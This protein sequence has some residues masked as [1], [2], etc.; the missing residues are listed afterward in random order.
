MAASAG[1]GLGLGTLAAGVAV[2]AVVGVVGYQVIFAPGPDPVAEG[3]P[4]GIAGDPV[5]VPDPDVSDPDVEVAVETPTAATPA[6]PDILPDLIAPRFD[7]V[8][9]D[10][11]GGALIAGQAES[12]AE[13]RLLLDGQEIHLASSDAGGDFVAMFDIPPSELPRI[14]SLEMLMEDGSVLVSEQSVII[15]P[16]LRPVGAAT[17]VE[18]AEADA[19][20]PDVPDDSGMTELSMASEPDTPPASGTTP[21]A[22]ATP[23]LPEQT[24]VAAGGEVGTAPVRENGTEV[25]VSV[26]DE[27]P[28]G[29]SQEPAALAEDTG[30]AGEPDLEIASLEIAESSG[31]GLSRGLQP[32]NAATDTENAGDADAQSSE[33]GADEPTQAAAGDAP[34]VILDTANV[35]QPDT[36]DGVGPV[37]VATEAPAADRDSPE[38]AGASGAD[39]PAALADGTGAPVA[40]DSS[41][42]VATASL[43]ENP[44]PVPE[45]SGPSAS[46]EGTTG[47]AT[48]EGVSVAVSDTVEDDTDLATTQGT[49]G[50]SADVD[51]AASGDASGTAEENTAQAAA[52]ESGDSPVMDMDVADSSADSPGVTDGNTELA[53]AQESGDSPVMDMDVADSSAD[54]QGATDGNTELA[55]AQDAADAPAAQNGAAVS[56][57]EAETQPASQPDVGVTEDGSGDS[58]SD[59]TQVAAAD[60]SSEAPQGRPVMEPQTPTVLLA[61][62]QGIRVIQSGDEAPQ[63]QSQVTLDTIAYDTVGDVVLAGRGPAESDVR[64]YLNNQPIHL[65]QINLQGGWR[66]ALP[67]VDPGTY[68]LRLDEVSADGAVQSRIETPFLRE[69]PEAVAAITSASGENV[70]TVQWGHTLWGIAQQH[71][72]EGVAYVQIYEANR[73]QIRNPDLIYPG[74]IFTLPERTD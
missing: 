31:G 16:T 13:L 30:D 5:A 53:A 3:V 42:E 24:G 46:S 55:A 52:Q 45:D 19:T 72:G 65:A 22:P 6:E 25:A 29:G 43:E 66:T 59:S 15:S 1:S 10:A 37:Q 35:P 51:M 36:G 64:F 62:S 39:D 4:Q 32:G 20:G 67:Q 40:E 60:S 71:F 27:M 44:V 54:P 21:L 2:A 26:A 34:Q 50:S 48:P 70:I 11:A 73:D 69:E 7:L 28:S 12:N 74:Q 47:L 49:G 17:G 14:L 33:A 63:V 8:R 61:D 38:I 23:D 41:Q 68:T 58:S 9:V 18:V 56:S 57:G